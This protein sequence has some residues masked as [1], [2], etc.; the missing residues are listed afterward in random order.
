MIEIYCDGACRNN[1]GSSNIGAY[2]YLLN[3]TDQDYKKAYVDVVRNTTNNRMELLA[4]ISALEALKPSA[5]KFEIKVFTDSQYVVRGV[6]EWSY[7]WIA[8]NF[9]GIKNAELWK[10][11]IELKNK[12][13][14]IKFIWVKGHE[15]NVGN[16]YVDTLCNDAMDKELR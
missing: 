6:N 14:N 7:N 10:R 9:Q 8:K 5:N 1:Q 11:L 3:L 12:F 15:D 13:S 4:A 16:L 2:A